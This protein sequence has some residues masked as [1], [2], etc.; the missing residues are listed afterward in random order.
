MS[1]RRR[2]A[3]GWYCTR[4]GAT[5]ATTGSGFITCQRCGSIGLRGFKRFPRRVSCDVPGCAFRGWDD[6]GVND[7]LGIHKRIDHRATGGQ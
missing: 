1:R 3:G 4:C 2:S 6:G 7:D 5:Y